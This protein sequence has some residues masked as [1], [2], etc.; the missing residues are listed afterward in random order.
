[1]QYGTRP[2]E[3][4]VRKNEIELELYNQIVTNYG[5]PAL[6]NVRDAIMEKLMNMD[7]DPETHHKLRVAWMSSFINSSFKG[8]YY[9]KITGRGD[10]TTK[11]WANKGGAAGGW[12]VGLEEPVQPN[13]KIDVEIR[14]SDV[15][16]KPNKGYTSINVFTKKD[17]GLFSIRMKW[18]SRPF[19]TAIKLSGKASH[20]TAHFYDEVVSEDGTKTTRYGVGKNPAI[21]FPRT[22]KKGGKA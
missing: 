17:V 13:N 10:F 5:G 20:V 3:T 6:G 4:R 2:G 14:K 18:A 22:G 12:Q 8:P 9:L 1:M 19:A 11:T 7:P 15:K 16:L 21:R